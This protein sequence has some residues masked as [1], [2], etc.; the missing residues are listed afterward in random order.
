MII[1][2]MM[3]RILGQI[4][5]SL[6]GQKG[7]TYDFASQ[8][9]NLFLMMKKRVT[10]RPVYTNTLSVDLSKT[11]TNVDD[12]V[13]KVMNL[14]LDYDAHCEKSEQDM[15]LREKEQLDVCHMV[16]NKLNSKVKNILNQQTSL[17]QI[18]K[19]QGYKH[20]AG[21]DALQFR[22]ALNTRSP[23]NNSGYESPHSPSEQYRERK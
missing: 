5:I 20:G 11:H 14:I 13:D 6:P 15:S 19:H 9:S 22:D 12:L 8:V 18:A 21:N 1:A 2:G 17:K 10:L 3:K 7:R 16:Q 23:A 4:P